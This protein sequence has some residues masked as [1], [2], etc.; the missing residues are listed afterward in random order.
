MDDILEG[1]TAISDFLCVSQKTAMRYW[2]KK[3]LPVVRN[4]A[5]HPVIEKEKIREWK[6][7]S[8]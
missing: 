3:D 4:K 2:K 8:V 1:W 7:Q 5:G 6:L